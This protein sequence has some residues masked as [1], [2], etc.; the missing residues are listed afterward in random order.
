MKNFLYVSIVFLFVIT[1][2]GSDDNGNSVIQ[3]DFTGTYTLTSVRTSEPLDTNDDGTFDDSELIDNITCVSFITLTSNNFTW[4]VIQVT[5]DGGNGIICLSVD[6]VSG[7]FTRNG[8][9]F[10]LNSNNITG[11]MTR[12]EN[13]LTYVPDAFN[14]GFF[15]GANGQVN[16]GITAMIYTK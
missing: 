5:G 12:N 8:D 11:T 13:E 15:N 10:I 14:Q 2:C 9:S 7:A 6:T 4:T 16:G 3:D 1:S